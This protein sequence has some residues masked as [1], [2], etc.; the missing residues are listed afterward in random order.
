[1]SLKLQR[2]TDAN[3]AL[4]LDMDS[5]KAEIKVVRET[6]E[7]V[8]AANAAKDDAVEASMRKAEVAL[9]GKA[10]VER[11]IDELR[12]S[13]ILMSKAK[14]AAESESANNRREL[15]ALKVESEDTKNRLRRTESAL[16]EARNDAAVGDQVAVLRN[17]MSRMRAQMVGSEMNEDGEMFDEDGNL[18]EGGSSP[19]K[20]RLNESA[21]M[22]A[23]RE[24]DAY[25]TVIGRLRAELADEAETRRQLITDLASARRDQAVSAGLQGDLDAAHHSIRKLEEEIASA[26]VEIA[27]ARRNE[28]N[29]V[30][31][32]T[33][34]ERS[35]GRINDDSSLL[36]EEL[37][38]AHEA[39]AKER[40]RADRYCKDLA[41]HERRAAELQAAK[42]RAESVMETA[43]QEAAAKTRALNTMR[44]GEEESLSKLSDLQK[45]YEEIKVQYARVLDSLKQE[46]LDKNAA[47]NEVARWK[48]VSVLAEKELRKE[49]VEVDEIQQRVLHYEEE[50]R[51]ANEFKQHQA[52]LIINL[53]EEITSARNSFSENGSL[54][55]GNEIAMLRKELETT[56]NDWGE[57]ERKRR[58]RE[59]RLVELKTSLASE[60]ERN[61]LLV[62]NLKLLEDQVSIAREELSV[63]RQLDVYEASV[64][65][66]FGRRGERKFGGGNMKTPVKR[67]TDGLSDSVAFDSP[68]S[69]VGGNTSQAD[70]M[71]EPRSPENTVEGKFRAGKKGAHQR[72]AEGRGTEE[73]D[74]DDDV[75]GETFTKSQL[76][77]AK[78]YLLKR[79][80]KRI[81]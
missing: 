18:I 78:E 32:S 9:S 44:E 57:A 34:A 13:V 72:N 19:R 40:A 35:I 30:A 25:E 23:K 73:S 41:D 62:T 36:V 14:R 70:F 46:Q 42:S 39:I 66:E 3:E 56:I 68:L 64:K 75:D 74:E 2:I 76:A 16:V 48:E 37:K 26:E 79:R 21:M 17:Q 24:R 10:I 51:L 31:V 12:N 65:S 27:K 29:A 1:M 4:A 61:S 69:L 45:N 54:K 49:D 67:L 22:E 60:Q 8:R 63:Y 11:E 33:E 52:K 43:T 7:S 81:A 50:L 55:A 47:L 80:N 15:D 38:E 59:D 5:K 58:D 77:S 28:L 71:V 53:Q 20:G 6:L